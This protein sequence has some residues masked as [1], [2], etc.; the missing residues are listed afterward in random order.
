MLA[1]WHS[2]ALKQGLA[3]FSLMAPE[4]APLLTL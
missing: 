4:R 2:I 3:V 1:I